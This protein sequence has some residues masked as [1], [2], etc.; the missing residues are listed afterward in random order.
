MPRV[1]DIAPLSRATHNVTVNTLVVK[2]TT[3]AGRERARSRVGCGLV[4]LPPA[5]LH[6]HRSELSVSGKRDEVGAISRVARPP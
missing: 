1:T 6:C 4:S 2:G 3:E 5:A